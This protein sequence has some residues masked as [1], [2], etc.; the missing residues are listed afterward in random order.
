MYDLKN[1]G[2]GGGGGLRIA[3]GSQALYSFQCWPIRDL[4]LLH[5]KSTSRVIN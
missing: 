4:V 1:V 3:Y 2:G 5:R